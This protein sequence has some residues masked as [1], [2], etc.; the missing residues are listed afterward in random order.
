[1]DLGLAGRSYLVTG[2]SQG[3]GREIVRLLLAEGAQVAAL[4]R[5][6]ARL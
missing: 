5:D 3:V 1:V 2:G 6:K 4:A